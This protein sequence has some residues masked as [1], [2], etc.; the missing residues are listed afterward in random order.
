MPDLAPLHDY[1]D[2]RAVLIGTWNYDHLPSIPAAGNSLRRMASL[3]T[4]ALCGWPE[5]RVLIVDNERSPGDLPDRLITAYEHVTDVALFYYV[6]HGQMDRDDQLCLGLAASRTEPNRRTATSLPFQ[7][8]RRALLDSPAATKIVILDCCFAALAN[9]PMNTLA[10]LADDVL[11]KTAGAGAYTMAASGPYTTAWFE[12]DPEIAQPQT[13]FT[14]YLADLVETGIAGEASG[15]KLH[16]L[17]IRVRDTL[18]RDHLPIPHERSVDAARDFVFAHNAAPL[19]SHRDLD[20]ELR[21]VTQRL[22]ET[23]AKR[24]QERLNAKAQEQALQIKA[25]ELAKELERLKEQALHRQSM[26]ASQQQ[27]LE[28]AIQET[29][30][31][32]DETTAAQT[33]AAERADA[34]HTISRRAEAAL[35]PLRQARPGSHRRGS[36]DPK[37]T[38]ANL[39]GPVRRTRSALEGWRAHPGLALL[40]VVL[41]LTVLAVGGIRIMSSVQSALAYQRTLQLADLG[42]DINTLVQRLQDER[43]QTAYFIAEGTNGGRAVASG[44]RAAGLQ[45]VHTQRQ[46]TERAAAVVMSVLGRVGGSFAPLVR[47]EASATLADLEYLPNLRLQATESRVAAPVVLQKYAGIISHLLALEQN[48]TRGASD[49]ALSQMVHVLGLVS[50]MKEDASQQ[51]AILTA[52]LIKHVLDPGARTALLTAQSD[53][54]AAATAFSLSATGPQ[55]QLFQN[56]LSRSL[57]FRA[58]Q[59]EQQALSMGTSL[60]NDPTRPDDFYGA[61]MNEINTQLGSVERNLASQVSTRAGALRRNSIITGFSILILLTLLLLPFALLPALALVRRFRAQRITKQ[62]RELIDDQG[63]T[64][65]VADHHG[66]VRPLPLAAVHDDSPDPGEDADAPQIVMQVLTADADV[67]ER[68][69]AGPDA[70][71]VSAAG[72]ESGG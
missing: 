61:M 30:R 55:R 23:E 62:Q 65:P 63:E 60:K 18:D 51:R 8:V 49:P 15:L 28:D 20:A 17:F 25:A 47:Q 68:A 52:A 72:G 11:D 12:T 19:E 46:D 13:F 14:K 58:N 70:P 9:Q 37:P 35:V 29:G 43:D 33:A 53:Q 32:L 50:R 39:T 71:G 31:R 40:A 22:A 67:A 38:N 36:S 57:V 16:R 1:S 3:L 21:L 66:G 48:T 69:V 64:A 2:S 45:V 44:S 5:D 6:G 24:A 54:A 4:G 26:A 42:S 27:E 59:E 10:A 34:A 7:A 41:S 56:S